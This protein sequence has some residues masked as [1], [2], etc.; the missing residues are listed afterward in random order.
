MLASLRTNRDFWAGLMLIGLGGAAVLIARDY[1]FGTAVRMGPGYFPS[2]LGGLLVVFGIYLLAKGLRSREQIEGN[3]SLRA[4]IVLPL[5]MVLFGVLM[6]RAGFIPALAVLIFGSALAGTEF[7]FIE[8]ALLTVG[9]TIFSVLV[10]IWGLG[11]P[12]PLLVGL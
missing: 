5:S 4:L 7:R 8:V 10:F 1:T 2:L 11:L 9:L 12:Y 6:D 3:W